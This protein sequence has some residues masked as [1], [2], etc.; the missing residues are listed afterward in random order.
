MKIIAFSDVH[1]QHPYGELGSELEVPECDVLI[2]AGDYS[3]RSGLD[4]NENFLKW[5]SKLFSKHKILIP[6]NHDYLLE[7][8]EIPKSINVLINEELIIDGV[9]FYGTP[10]TP[11]FCG[12]NYM[13]SE[14]DLVTCYDLIPEDTDVLISHG[15]PAGRLDNFK[16]S[17]I[18]STSLEKR[19]KQVRP[20]IHIFGHNHA[21]GF[22]HKDGTDFYNVS[23]LNQDYV[24]DSEVTEIE[25]EKE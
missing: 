4:A 21:N 15:P 11:E 8:T 25:Y 19:V 22:A 23:I 5:F 1:G 2:F 24:K 10:Y 16:D 18:G 12:W 6:G 20:D 9:K 3:W 7:V 13:A 14:E 17:R